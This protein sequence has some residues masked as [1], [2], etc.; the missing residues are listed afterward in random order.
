MILPDPSRCLSFLQLSWHLALV[1]RGTLVPPICE[2]SH[3]IHFCNT[4]CD[5]N[6]H[7]AVRRFYYRA[8]V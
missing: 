1:S 6:I 5:E 3:G 2:T 4:L 7:S 8:C